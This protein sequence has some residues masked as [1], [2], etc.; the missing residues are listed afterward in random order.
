[1][2]KVKTLNVMQKRALYMLFAWALLFLPGALLFSIN[3]LNRE[4]RNFIYENEFLSLVTKLIAILWMVSYLFLLSGGSVAI[5]SRF[6]NGEVWGNIIFCLGVTS[7]CSAAWFLL[8][9]A[10]YVVS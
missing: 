4:L 5:Y 6:K 7:V 2:R 1:M 3:D 9:L 10:A 8:S